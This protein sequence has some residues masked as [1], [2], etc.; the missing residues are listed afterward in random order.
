MTINAHGTNYFAYSTQEICLFLFVGTEC[1][2]SRIIA[3][4]FV[5]GIEYIKLVSK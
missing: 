1:I 3:S 4:K 2:F 5:S